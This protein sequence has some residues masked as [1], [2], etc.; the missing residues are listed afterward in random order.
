MSH[1]R[2]SILFD[3]NLASLYHLLLK[4][5]L[6]EA[7]QGG[8]EMQTPISA[9]PHLSLDDPAIYLVSCLISFYLGVLVGYFYRVIRGHDNDKPES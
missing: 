8:K 4:T 3:L 2:T 6:G 9:V 7:I 5:W 1:N